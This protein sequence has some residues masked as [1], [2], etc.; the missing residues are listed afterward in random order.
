L[1]FDPQIYV[2]PAWPGENL[3]AEGDKNLPHRL[4]IDIKQG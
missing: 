4:E 1:F 2:L 3:V